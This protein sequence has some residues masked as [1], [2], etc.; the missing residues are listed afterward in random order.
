MHK[1]LCRSG[2]EEIS[3]RVLEHTVI[4]S[5][6]SW[7]LLSVFEPDRLFKSSHLI[8]LVWKLLFIFQILKWGHWP[9]EF[10]S[11]L[12]SFC[13]PDTA[14][15]HAWFQRLL[16]QGHHL[17]LFLIVP[18]V[19]ILT[20]CLFLGKRWW[21]WNRVVGLQIKHGLCFLWNFIGCTLT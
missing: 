10:C 16:T 21:E 18:V 3:S 4:N 5:H 15:K 11:R 13:L 9:L 1:I 17:W 12:Q 2:R 6:N 14:S 19:H 8:Q 20:I 7:Y